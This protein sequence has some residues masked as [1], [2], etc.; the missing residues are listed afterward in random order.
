MQNTRILSCSS[1][2][3][4]YLKHQDPLV[5]KARVGKTASV[6]EVNSILR[7]CH[8]YSFLKPHFGDL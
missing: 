2:L 5:K 8:F 1:C 3:R 6:D 4:K 7:C